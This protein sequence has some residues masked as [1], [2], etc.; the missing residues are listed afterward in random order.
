[1]RIGLM[2]GPERGR[3]REKAAK[4]VA[5]AEAAEAAGFT[6]IWVPQI[7]DEFDAL[8]AVALMG[9]ATSRVELG[10]A[11]MP[12]QSRHPV[13]MAQQAL[14]VQSV[15]EGRFTLGLGPSHHWIVDDMLGLPYERPAALVRD[16][17]EV[18]NAAFDGPGPVDVQN[19]TYRIHNPLDVTDIAPTPI[20][21]AALAP[22]M[23]RVAGEHAS[24]TILWMAD[25]RAIGDHVVPRITKAAEEA[26]RPRPRIVAGIPVAVCPNDEV[27]DARA[28]ANRVL[29]HAEYSPNYERLLE[30]GDATDVGDLL[31]A[32]DEP[33]VLSR[34]RSF[35]DAGATDLSFRILPL[36]PDRDARIASRQRTEAFLT[37]VAAEL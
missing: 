37:T 34:L 13:A 2:I 3:Y 12:I 32:G 23:L 28:R 9:Q 25:E 21:V 5:D 24:G 17:L 26:G 29:G 30:R 1:M 11:V 22:V 36:G 6:S 16:Y 8:T 14:A 10:T 20:L 27:D 7:P 35:R 18:L 33:A 15:C 4:L 19:D 31:A